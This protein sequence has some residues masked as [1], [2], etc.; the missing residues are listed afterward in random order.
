MTMPTTPNPT[1]PSVPLWQHKDDPEMGTAAPE[2]GRMPTPQVYTLN[3][4]A[5]AITR[6]WQYFIRAINHKM[7][8]K[9]VS[10]I[11][12][13]RRAFCNLKG[14]NDPEFPP[15][16]DYLLRE[17]LDRRDPEFDK[18]R[19]CALAVMTGEG[20][21]GEL[22]VTMLD[23]SKPPPLKEGR[24]YPE[25]VE[26]INVDDYLY[27]PQMHRHFFCAANIINRKG[28]TVPFPNG[29]VYDWTGDQRLYTWLPHVAP[30]QIKVHYKLSNL[31]KLPAGAPIPSA[32]RM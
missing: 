4:K 28:E 30:V 6:Q 26:D 23:G 27:T 18:V 21:E 3:D 9:K 10:A 29:A 20:R 8:L 16:A 7:D 32:Y 24:S 11:F 2:R 5:M 17:N 14:F 25:R 19:T 12:G 22:F 31:T 15:R 13:S 1:L